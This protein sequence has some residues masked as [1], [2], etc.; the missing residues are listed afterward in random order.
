MG[1]RT[2]NKSF[3]SKV[4]H[5]SGHYKSLKEDF[6]IRPMKSENAK[7]TAQTPEAAQRK[8]ELAR[9]SKKRV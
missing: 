5:F 7:T 4:F 8:L 2:A 3:S 1:G 6:N 9:Q